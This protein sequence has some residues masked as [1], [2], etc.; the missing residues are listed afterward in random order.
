MTAPN[1]DGPEA[2]GW[3]AVGLRRAAD[4]HEADRERIVRR[5]G[6]DPAGDA[7]PVRNPAGI[8][9]VPDG[10][11]G[12]REAHPAWRLPRPGSRFAAALPIGVAAAAVVVATVVS[13]LV[14]TSRSEPSVSAPSPDA[15]SFAASP[16]APAPPVTAGPLAPTT[17]PTT[18]GPTTSGPTTSGPAG[19]PAAAGRASA[20]RPSGPPGRT[21]AAGPAPG[22]TP[23]LPTVVPRAPA[24]GAGSPP[25][26]NPATAGVRPVSAGSS[27]T[28]GGGDWATVVRRDGTVVKPKRAVIGA[29][30]VRWTGALPGALSPYLVTWSGGA[31]EQ[32]HRSALT[33]LAIGPGGSATVTVPPLPAAST[34]TLYLGTAAADLTVSGAGRAT[35][36]PPGPGL[37]AVVVTVRLPASS[38]SAGVTV[39]S[40]NAG[41]TGV[42]GLAA[43]TLS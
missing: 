38:A 6:F 2:P 1:G 5:L 28:L 11:S 35:W 37:A 32:S 42:V 9:Y 40:T 26:S 15:G 43:A 23:S 31:P 29:L 25:G 30:D 14:A 17:P 22:A 3:V 13:V 24:A 19:P 8:G 10:G 33:W 21:G 36:S 7:A 16:T 18:P 39:A 27:V 20:A 41:S 12:R 4:A 34:L